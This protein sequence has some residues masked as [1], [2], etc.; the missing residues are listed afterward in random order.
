MKL[1][2][3]NSENLLFKIGV[4]KKMRWILKSLETKEILNISKKIVI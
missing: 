4:N 1:D 2:S 3:N